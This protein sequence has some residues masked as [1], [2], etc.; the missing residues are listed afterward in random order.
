MIST[1]PLYSHSDAHG[2]C[3]AGLPGIWDVNPVSHTM[4]DGISP[5]ACS[6]G[7]SKPENL[8]QGAAARA[9]Q[10]GVPCACGEIRPQRRAQRAKRTG[11]GMTDASHRMAKPT[12]QTVAQYLPPDRRVAMTSPVLDHLE[13]SCACPRDQRVAKTSPLSNHLDGSCACLLDR[14]STV[15]RP[16]ARVT[17]HVRR[18]RN[19]GN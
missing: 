12:P 3:A 17:S 2:A 9:L 1:G 18:C 11:F 8:T 10:R 5:S 14:R 4:G 19:H 16:L 15:P 13:G 6:S 7:L